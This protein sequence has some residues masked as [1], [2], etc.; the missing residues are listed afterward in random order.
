MIY[1]VALTQIRSIQVQVKEMNKVGWMLMDASRERF[2]E[3]FEASIC[4]A[5]VI[6]KARERELVD[7]ADIS[8]FLA[9]CGTPKRIRSL[10]CMTIEKAWNLYRPLIA[11]C[12]V[13]SLKEFLTSDVRDLRRYVVSTPYEIQ[14]LTFKLLGLSPSDAFA[15]FGSDIGNVLINALHDVGVKSALGYEISQETATL[16]EMRLDAAGYQKKAA[17]LRQNVFA[18]NPKDATFDKVFCSPPLGMKFMDDCIRTYVTS[19]AALPE[20][21]PSCSSTWIF[22]LRALD[23]LKPTGKGVVIV[24]D[25]S[26]FNQTELSC[27]KYLMDRNLIEAVISLP[28]PIFAGTGIA[29]SIVLLNPSKK[30][31][32]VLMVDASQLGRRGKGLVVLSEREIDQIADIVMSGKQ[33]EGIPYERIEANVVAREEFILHPRRYIKSDVVKLE[34]P[35]SKPLKELVVSIRRGSSLTPHEL[36][37]LTAPERTPFHYITQANIKDGIIEKD[38]PSLKSMPPAKAAYCAKNGDII[39]TQ[40]GRPI[41]CAVACLNDGEQLLIGSNQYIITPDERRIDPFFLKTF[42]DSAIGQTVLAQISVGVAQP[43]IALRDLNEIRIPV[44]P[45]EKQKSIALAYRARQDEVEILRR[46][47]DRSLSALNGVFEE[48]IKED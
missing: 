16:A 27:R 45:M 17:V 20:L 5:Y 1:C 46:K 23:S 47:L 44:V 7:V 24:N 43:A 42:F 18:V 33:N 34:F 36:S 31:T 22:A 25:G 19:K 41:K 13:E 28:T 9:E 11:S 38:I 35:D 48:M 15:D 40:V 10:I 21:R 12:D 2:P 14:S 29:T 39:L 8:V 4:A 37:I 26:L 6:L 3:P 30:D 32:S